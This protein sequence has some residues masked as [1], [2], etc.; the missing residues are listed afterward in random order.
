MF[1]DHN[2]PR[3][4][5]EAIGFAVM[6]FSQLE[7]MVNFHACVTMMRTTK[8]GDESQA[9][10]RPLSYSAKVDLLEAMLKLRADEGCRSAAPLGRCS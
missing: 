4:V 1:S 5:G 9:L 7:M 3:S 8:C 6:A 2:Q 10:G